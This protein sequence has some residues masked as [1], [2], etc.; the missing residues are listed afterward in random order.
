MNITYFALTYSIYDT[1]PNLQLVNFMEIARKLFA[2]FD[3]K[4]GKKIQ[5]IPSGAQILRR[6]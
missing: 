2:N 1:S 6:L 3:K 5:Y 4:M